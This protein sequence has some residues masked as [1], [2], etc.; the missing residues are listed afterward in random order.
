[1]KARYRYRFYPTNQQK[2]SLAQL[3]GCVRVVFNDALA[4]CKKSDKLPTTTEL[5][6]QIITQAK[7]TKDRAWLCEVSSVA[8]QQSVRNLGVAYKNFFD[9]VKGKRKGKK[10]K[11]PK[12]KKRKN[13]QSAKLTRNAFSINNES[14]YLAKIGTVKPIWSRELP[15][16]PS[17]VTII[18]DSAD[19]YFLSFVVEVR[20]A[21]AKPTKKTIGIDLGIKTFATFDTGEKIDAPKPLKK[22]LKRLRKLQRHLSRK[23]KGSNRRELSRRKVA[24]LH[25]KIKD[26]RTDFL[27]K[28]S[29]QIIRDNQTIVLED[30]NVSG[31][32]KNRKLS[33][34][35]SDL[36]W[37]E[38]RTFLEAKA[39]KYDRGFRVIDRWE[40]TSQ[41]CS[42]C[43]FRGGKLDL[44]IREW[45]CLNCESVHDRDV[46]A[47]INIQQ[48]ADK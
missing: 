44:S 47:A 35:I 21:S 1:M 17:S 26:L 23:Q 8:L 13:Q 2:K 10:I 37:R 18:K 32:M 19:R 4:L 34:A 27:H 24:K 20:K 45:Q 11:S 28:L 48:I 46:N 36:G 15:S 12:F 33:R 22:K 41:T 31:M 6:N 29:T 3:F 39:E 9:S 16:V 7:K 40:P 30:L 43:G 5:S 42:S 38:F 25:A 14:V